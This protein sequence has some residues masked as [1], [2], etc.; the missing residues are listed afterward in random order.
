MA[1]HSHWAGIKHKKKIVDA[2]RGR[3]FSKLARNITS[4]ARTGGKDVEANLK[5]KYAIEKA[6]AANMPKDNI[7]RAI[8]KGTGEL[9]GETLDEVVYEGYGPGGVAIFLEA[10]TDN[11]N[12]TASE[13][14]HMFDKRGGSMGASGCVGWMFEKKA[15]F[16]I[17]RAALDEDAAMALA[18]EAGAE[19]LHTESEYYEIVGAPT[20]FESIRK[21]L[22]KAGLEPTL[23]ELTYLPKTTVPVNA[24]DGKKVLQL[25]EE[26]EEH[27]DIQNAFSNFDIPEEVMREME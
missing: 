19:D 13:I 5:L 4:A 9:E 26:F 1:G 16:Q 24:S 12:R 21:G 23:A 20:D 11:R 2:R 7:E 27:E 22:E 25:L 8:K 17:D 6:R 15:I 10:L 18:M 14:R 3:L